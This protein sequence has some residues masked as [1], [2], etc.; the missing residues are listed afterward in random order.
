[1]TA[2]RRSGIEARALGLFGGDHCHEVPLPCGVSRTNHWREENTPP[3]VAGMAPQY[4]VTLHR[5]YP[6]VYWQELTHGDDIPWIIPR[7]VKVHGLIGAR[8]L[9]LQMGGRYYKQRFS[10]S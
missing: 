5:I 1:M 4:A 9:S 8:H 2:Q 6:N 7:A 3:V 10:Q